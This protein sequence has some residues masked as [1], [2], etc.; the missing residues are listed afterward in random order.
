MN[1]GQQRVLVIDILLFS[2]LGNSV[3]SF[4]VFAKERTKLSLKHVGILALPVLVPW[5]SCDRIGKLSFFFIP[6]LL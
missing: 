6:P 1:H 3:L 4:L 2:L 5:F